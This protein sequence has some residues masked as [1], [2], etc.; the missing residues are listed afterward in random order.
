[1]GNRSQVHILQLA[2][3][4]HSACQARHQNAAGLQGFADRMGRSFPLHRETG[5]QDDLLHFPVCE[6]SEE[7]AG[8]QI[9]GATAIGPNL[10]GLAKAMNDLSRGCSAEDIVGTICVTLLQSATK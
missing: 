8:V 10:Q 6:T 7:F 3:N 1:M 9:G 2:A 4:G 5:R